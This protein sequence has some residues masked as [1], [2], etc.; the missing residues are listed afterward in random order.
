MYFTPRGLDEREQKILD[1]TTA[2]R[3]LE[4][5]VSGIDISVFFKEM[6]MK[7]IVI[8]AANHFGMCLVKSLKNSEIQVSCFVD[9]DYYKYT[10]EKCMGI[11]IIPYED[12]GKYAYADAV[13]VASNYYFN[14]ITDS[15]IK[16]GIKLENILSINDILFGVERIR[17]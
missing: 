14:E 8:A 4:I 13:I 2:Q 16:N 3:Y 17:R 9:K 1:C 5:A 12:I 10:D 15:L 11:P 7:N 6:G